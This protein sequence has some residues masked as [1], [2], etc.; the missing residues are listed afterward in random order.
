M[1]LSS[2]TLSPRSNVISEPYRDTPAHKILFYIAD[3]ELPVVKDACRKA[4]IRFSFGETIIKMFKG[5]YTPARDDRDLCRIRDCGGDGNIKSIPRPIRFHA[6]QQD[7]AGTAFLCFPGPCNSI[8]AGWLAAPVDDNFIPASG[9]IFQQHRYRIHVL[10][11][12]ASDI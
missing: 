8:N 12:I 1:H 7:L 3:G 11:I 5:T 6:R 10:C 4:G 9:A 2:S